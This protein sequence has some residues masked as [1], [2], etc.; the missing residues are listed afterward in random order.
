[1]DVKGYVGV[2]FFYSPSYETKHKYYKNCKFYCRIKIENTHLGNKKQTLK[3]FCFCISH[4]FIAAVEWTHLTNEQL[5][6][7]PYPSPFLLETSYLRYDDHELL[8]M[9]SIHFC[10]LILSQYFSLLYMLTNSC[11]DSLVSSV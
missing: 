5:S 10:F 7:V 2:T 9:H 4:D 8:C 6:L 1:M 11:F 3:L